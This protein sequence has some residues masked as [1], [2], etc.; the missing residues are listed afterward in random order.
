[1]ED[2][3]L[4]VEYFIK[5]YCAANHWTLKRVSDEVME[6]MKRYPWPGN[7]RELENLVQ[8]MVV[9]TDEDVIPLKQLP[10]DIREA[11]PQPSADGFCLP[12]SG[13]RL[14]EEV[15]AFEKRWVETALEKT[16]GVK[17]EA[18]HLLG[19]NKDKLKYL[20]RKHGI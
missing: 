11:A 9:M 5:V 2:I 17:V 10:R 12:A 8:R 13:I 19:L 7:V 1:V 16:K 20:C 14:E 18:A 3:P 6:A 15:K 4:L